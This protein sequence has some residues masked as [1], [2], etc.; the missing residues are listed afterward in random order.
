M[1]SLDKINGL[2]NMLQKL[3]HSPKESKFNSK[4]K[5]PGGGGDYFLNV[6]VHGGILLA[7][8]SC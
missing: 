3:R 8:P 7:S 4:I 5:F 1:H 2:L 6:P